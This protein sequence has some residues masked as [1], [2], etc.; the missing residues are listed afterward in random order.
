MF[1]PLTFPVHQRSNPEMSS[2]FFRPLGFLKAHKVNPPSNHGVNYF[3]RFTSVPIL[4]FSSAQTNHT[5]KIHV[6]KSYYLAPYP[7]TNLVALDH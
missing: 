5:L 7:S 3:N 6:G 2:I 1:L 4:Q